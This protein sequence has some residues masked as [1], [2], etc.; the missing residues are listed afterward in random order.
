[1]MQQEYAKYPVRDYFEAFTGDLIGRSILDYGCNHANFLRYKSFSGNYTG[2]DILPNVIEFNKKQY[3]EH[4]W[5]LLDKFNYQYR[6]EHVEEKWPKLEKY[7]Y[8][9]A[10]SVFTHTDEIEFIDT[11]KKLKEHCTSILA[12]FM[13]TK[14]RQSLVKIFNY[15]PE[16]F[17]NPESLADE[18]LNR[19]SVYVACSKTNTCVNNIPNNTEY[20]LHFYNDDYIANKLNAQV[21]R[22]NDNFTNVMSVQR[23]LVI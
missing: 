21:E 1:M 9:L 17:D 15:R 20:Y 4:N 23:L 8:A 10:Y 7:D 22:P 3:P 18:I 13:S 2:L 6:N 16:Y 5:L 11:K 19:D 14:D 12:T